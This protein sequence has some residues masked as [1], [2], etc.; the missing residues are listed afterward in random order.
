MIVLPVPV[1]NAIGRQTSLFDAGLLIILAMVFLS[2]YTSISGIVKAEMFP[3][4]I[5]GLGVGFTYAIGNSL[6]G[7][8]AEYVALFMKQHGYGE[9]FPWYVTGIAVC[10]L[11]AVLFMH[12]NREHSTIDNPGSSAYGKRR[13]AASS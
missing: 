6:F 9:V 8:S 10:G 12:D 1:L 7:G 3:A 5:R 13:A 2:F 11:I 4:Y